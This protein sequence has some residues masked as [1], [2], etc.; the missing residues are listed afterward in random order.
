VYTEDQKRMLTCMQKV[1]L[2]RTI[3]QSMPNN[4]HNWIY[5]LG[6]NHL[7][8]KNRHELN[9]HNLNSNYMQSFNPHFGG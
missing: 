9:G 5:R 2:M 6:G 1:S 8:Q 4:E 3:G 7:N